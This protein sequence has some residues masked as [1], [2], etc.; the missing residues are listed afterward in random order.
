MMRQDDIE[1]GV[2]VRTVLVADDLLEEMR[3][4]LRRYADTVVSHT[5]HGLV[6]LLFGKHLDLAA[7][8]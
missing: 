1:D 8:G 2:Q 6:T 7:L 4:H 5:D 3:H